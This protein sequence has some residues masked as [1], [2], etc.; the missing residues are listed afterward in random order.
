MDAGDDKLPLH[1]RRWI[2]IGLVVAAWT[3]IIWVIRGFF[4]A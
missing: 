1:V 4:D 3:A 2:I